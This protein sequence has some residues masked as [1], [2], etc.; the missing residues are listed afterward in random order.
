MRA[1][2]MPVGIQPVVAASGWK[3][4]AIAEEH[5][6]LI[7]N[8]ACDD[9]GGHDH[10]G[11]EVAM[12]DGRGGEG[13]QRT[14]RNGAGSFEGIRKTPDVRAIKRSATCAT[15]PPRRYRSSR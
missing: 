7:V 2:R 4:A 6:R 3:S 10:H 13:G 1:K 15:R 9:E 8:A 5:R 14:F 11:D 12:L